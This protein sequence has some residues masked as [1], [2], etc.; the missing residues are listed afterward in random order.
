MTFGER[1]I[2][3]L[4]F[5]IRR[6]AGDTKDFTKMPRDKQWQLKHKWAVEFFKERGIIDAAVRK[7]EA[8]RGRKSGAAEG[9]E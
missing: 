2:D 9:G 3:D 7:S 6:R 8:A 1:A 4:R 5:Y